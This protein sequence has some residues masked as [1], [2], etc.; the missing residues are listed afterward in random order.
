MSIIDSDR[1]IHTFI[2]NWSLQPFSQDYDLASHTNFMFCALI[3]IHKWWNLQFK[4]DSERQI[5][6]QIFLAEFRSEIC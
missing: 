3:F 2:H 1:D 5:S 6:G 4:V